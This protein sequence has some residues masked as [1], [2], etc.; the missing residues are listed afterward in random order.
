MHQVYRQPSVPYSILLY[1]KVKN[2]KCLMGEKKQL[3]W[4]LEKIKTCPVW[5]GDV[6]GVEA[7]SLEVYH[8]PLSPHDLAALKLGLP[9]HLSFFV[10]QSSKSA[11]ISAGLFPLEQSSP[12]K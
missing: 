7:V 8:F 6:S 11:W 9:A 10:L 12:A 3:A 5:S 1:T 4:Q 2:E